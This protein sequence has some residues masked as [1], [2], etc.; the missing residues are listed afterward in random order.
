MIQSPEYWAEIQKLMGH[1]FYRQHKDRTTAYIDHF[2]QHVPL[3]DGILEIGGYPGLLLG[4]LR[5][6]GYL[7]LTSI[8]SPKYRPQ[9]YLDW[10]K[11]HYI[12]SIEHDICNGALPI[13]VRFDTAIMSDVL[14]HIEGFPLEFI[15]WTVQH[16]GQLILINF[17]GQAMVVTAPKS[18]SLD[19]GFSL[20]SSEVIGDAIK[21]FAKIVKEV[22]IVDRILL[23]IKAN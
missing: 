23:V 1:D 12:L 4:A 20:P 9:I 16:C 2:V 22:K 21:D 8:D 17:P 10:C 11:D 5:Q 6:A 14:L 18:H 13:N 19:I 3:T 7:F 15:K